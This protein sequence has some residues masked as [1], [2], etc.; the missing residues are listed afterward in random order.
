MGSA[1]QIAKIA[2]HPAIGIARVGNSPDEFYFGPEV[3]EQPPIESLRDSKGRL[4][5]QAARFRV[6]A[7]DENRYVMGELTSP[8]ADIIWTVHIANKKAAWFEFHT[9]LDIPLPEVKSIPSHRN[10]ARCETH[11]LM[12][13]KG[14]NLLSTLGI[15]GLPGG[16]R[17]VTV[18]WTNSRLKQEHSSTNV[19][20]WVSCA[21]TTTDAWSCW[22]EE[23]TLVPKAIVRS[24]PTRTPTTTG[25]MTTFPTDPLT[26]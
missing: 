7:Y 17:I 20:T 11:S 24:L 10:R 2:I 9:P 16:A 25:G 13:L 6:F 26:Q 12:L 22:E 23:A 1:R 19:S 21:P 8:E 4:K 18:I 5:R 14:R 15:A 3:P